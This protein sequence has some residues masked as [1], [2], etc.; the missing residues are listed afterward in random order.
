MRSDSELEGVTLLGGSTK[1]P[2]DYSPSI[3]GKE[4]KRASLFVTN[5]MLILDWRKS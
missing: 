5:R 4:C 3:L 2:T 1:Y